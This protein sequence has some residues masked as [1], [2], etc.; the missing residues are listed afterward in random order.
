MNHSKETIAQA[1]RL[2]ARSAPMAELQEFA[3]QHGQTASQ[4]VRGAEGKPLMGRSPITIEPA[5]QGVL[6]QIARG[7]QPDLGS[8]NI[9]DGVGESEWSRETA[10]AGDDDAVKAAIALGK[11]PTA[12]QKDAFKSRWGIS[13]EG[14]LLK[15][16][17]KEKAK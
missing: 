2:I 4:V 11:N 7:E 1:R 15:G 13:F 8:L 5:A 14:A 9:P 16:L 10:S 12:S 6:A 3:S 17:A